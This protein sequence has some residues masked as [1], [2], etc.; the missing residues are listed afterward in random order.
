[1][2][3]IASQIPKNL[4]FRYRIAC[5]K[6]SG[7]LTVGK[8]LNESYKIPD[9]GSL[10]EQSSFGDVR[11]GWSESGLLIQVAVTDKTKS[12]WCRETAILESD[13]LQVWIDTRDTHNIHRA[14]KFCHWFVMLPT[15]GEGKK[16]ASISTMLKINSCWAIA[17]KK[18][19]SNLRRVEGNRT[20]V[21]YR[22]GNFVGP[23]V[24][25][26][27]RSR[28]AIDIRRHLQFALDCGIDRRTGETGTE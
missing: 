27:I 24:G 25:T 6:V 9:L 5:K 16:N 21:T 12:L 19:D 7:K 2:A 3:S 23:H 17:A 11:I 14:S 4:P 28:L 20:N 10:D 15:G 13:G 18:T 1:M 26:V 22:T 8:S